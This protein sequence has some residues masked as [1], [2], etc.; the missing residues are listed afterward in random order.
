MQICAADKVIIPD[1]SFSLK[2]GELVALLGPEKS[3]KT[4]VLRAIA[5]LL[6]ITQGKIV[7]KGEHISAPD[8]RLPPHKRSCSIIYKQPSLFEHMSIQENIALTVR[9]LSRRNQK[10]VVKQMLNLVDLPQQKNIYP[11]DLSPENLQRAAL[12]TA[13]APEPTLLLWDEPFSQLGVEHRLEF[14]QEV[15]EILQEERVTTLITSTDE[16]DAYAVAEQAGVIN[17][18][19]LQQWDTPY[20]LYHT[21]KTRFVAQFVGRGVLLKSLIHDN[22]TVISE[23]GMLKLDE[24]QTDNVGVHF[25]ILVRP[26]DII[27][28]PRGPQKATVVGKAFLGAQTLYSLELSSGDRILALFSSHVDLGLGKSLAFKVEMDHLIAFPKTSR[29]AIELG[30]A[31]S[32]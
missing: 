1:L 25:D 31:H 18:G 22:N 21:P 7:L 5:G 2:K 13:L 16:H 6:P 24:S 26:D 12:A 15:H 14:A 17:E 3:G 11:Q 27:H 9:Q 32:I 10:L 23:L 28:S 29:T 8:Y 30:A 20:N 4:T 19:E